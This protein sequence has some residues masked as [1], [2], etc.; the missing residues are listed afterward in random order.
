MTAARPM[1]DPH[2]VGIDV[3]GTKIVGAVVNLAKG[4]LMLRHHIQPIRGVVAIRRWPMCV[5]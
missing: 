1:N 5:S 4:T 2:S 3:G